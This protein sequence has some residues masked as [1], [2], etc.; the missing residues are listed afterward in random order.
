MEIKVNN[1]K[2]LEKLEKNIICRKK[3]TRIPIEKCS[4][5][6]GKLYFSLNFLFYTKNCVFS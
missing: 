5:P 1:F 2:T 4:F 6:I 3:K